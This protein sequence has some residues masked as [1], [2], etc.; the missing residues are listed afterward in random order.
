VRQPVNAPTVP[1]GD[2]SALLI[3]VRS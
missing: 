3:A 1:G 2:S